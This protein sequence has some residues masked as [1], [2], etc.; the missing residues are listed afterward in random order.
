MS[1][2][3]QNLTLSDERYLYRKYQRGD[4]RSRDKLLISMNSRMPRYI[5]EVWGYPEKN[6]ELEPDDILSTGIMSICEGFDEYDPDSKL[7]FRYWALNMARYGI[8]RFIFQN[9]FPM[10]LPEGVRNI[11]FKLVRDIHSHGWTTQEYL[12]ETQIQELS[13]KHSV[14]PEY[15]MVISAGILDHHGGFDLESIP[16]PDTIMVRDYKFQKQI[17]STMRK[18]MK[19]NE[20]NV[21]RDRM[22]RTDPLTLQE[23]GDKLDLTR[24]RVNQIEKEAFRKA[25]KVLSDQLRKHQVGLTDVL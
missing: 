10:T 14:R 2:S 3:E 23:V 19:P 15:V 13:Q 18:Q 16:E 17:I 22:M 4:A 21:T 20:W 24:Q 25:K 12:T 8:L 9:K 5:H 6:P 7:H 11:F 1:E